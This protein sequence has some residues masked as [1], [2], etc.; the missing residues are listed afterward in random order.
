MRVLVSYVLLLLTASLTRGQVVDTERGRVEFIG[1]KHWTVT[2]LI[3]ALRAVEPDRPLH[4]CAAVLTDKLGFPDASVIIYPGEGG[5]YTVVTVIEPEDS[6]RVRYLRAPGDTMA[7]V[8]GWQAAISM[9]EDDPSVVQMGLLYYGYLLAGKSDSAHSIVTDL[10]DY[11]DPV[12]VNALWGFLQEHGGR[13]D[14]ELALRTLTNDG[15]AANRVIAAALLANSADSDLTWWRL[16][17]ALRDPDAQVRST[18]RDVLFTLSMHV[19]REVDWEPATGSLRWLLN[20]TNLFAFTAT[21]DLLRRTRVPQRLTGELLSDNAELLLAYLNAEHEMTR[22]TAQEFLV[23][24]SG[25]EYTTYEQ[26]EHW[27]GQLTRDSR[28]F[29]P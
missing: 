29:R 26:W 3:D 19:P 14:R 22:Q 18:A 9:F 15:N 25:L 21:L 28:P 24:L 6:A 5:M 23:Q 1:L 4:A 10:A 27:I 8:A 16:V 11:T 20:G 13:K 2:G 12:K 17:D 7:P